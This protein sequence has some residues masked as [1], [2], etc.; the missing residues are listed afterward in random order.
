MSVS[1]AV[2]HMLCNLIMSSPLLKN[3]HNDI[4]VDI[5]QFTLS[6]SNI[7]NILKLK[8]VCTTVGY[9]GLVCL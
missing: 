8:S 3:E 1:E 4:M 9:N 7:A 6:V 2:N 5:F